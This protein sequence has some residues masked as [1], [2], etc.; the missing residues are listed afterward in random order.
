MAWAIAALVFVVAGLAWL[1]AEGAFGE[2]PE[3]V[4]DRP[5]PRL[6][7]GDFTTDDLAALRFATVPRGYHPAQV[8]QFLQRVRTGLTPGQDGAGVTA[9]EVNESSFDLVMFGLSTAQ[10]DEV[11]ARLAHQLSGPRAGV[12]APTYGRMDDE[13]LPGRSEEVQTWQQ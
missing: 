7:A 3:H 4:D 5:V 13:H 9:A 6:P 11:L 12:E 1:V 8:R 2:Q 10:V